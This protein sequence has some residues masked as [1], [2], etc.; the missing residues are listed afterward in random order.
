MVSDCCCDFDSAKGVSGNQA[1]ELTSR[2]SGE[3]WDTHLT[4]KKKKRNN[5]EPGAQQGKLPD[6][7]QYRMDKERLCTSVGTYRG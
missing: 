4:K 3:E 6:G 7:E 2:E 5:T 1:E